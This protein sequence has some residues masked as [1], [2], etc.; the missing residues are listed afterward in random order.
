MFGVVQGGSSQGRAAP[1]NASN[2]ETQTQE[3]TLIHAAHTRDSPH[4]KS[5]VFF[6]LWCVYRHPML[7]L[8]GF[9]RGS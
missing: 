3:E 1:I 4:G 5:L 7:H 9:D 2:E 8:G 6:P